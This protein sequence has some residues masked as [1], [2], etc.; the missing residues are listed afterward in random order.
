MAGPTLAAHNVPPFSLL[1]LFRPDGSY[2]WYTN[3]KPTATGSSIYTS[4]T[5]QEAALQDPESNHCSTIKPGAAGARWDFEPRHPINLAKA[6]ELTTRITS[7]NQL[8]EQQVGKDFDKEDSLRTIA[9]SERVR[10]GLQKFRSETV[11]KHVTRIEALVLDSLQQLLRKQSLVSELRID[12]E[13]F[14][15]ELRNADGKII[16]ADRLSAGERQLLAVSLLWGLA[17]V[18][19]RPVPVVTDTPLGRLDASHRTHL[20]ERY[21][22]QASHQMLLL[23]TDK[24]IDRE[25]Y[26]RLKPWI[27]HSYRLEF[28][29]KSGS[30]QI[31]PGYF[32]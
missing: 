23:S 2:Q 26:D 30:T 6:G 11:R 31:Q 12:P 21:F 19:G 28:N 14:I 20:V 18:S 10:D 15:V 7:A 13:R 8:V 27:G 9:H 17:R 3:S 25:Y 24:E 29:E 16:G 22:P 4:A 1:I 5:A 32:W